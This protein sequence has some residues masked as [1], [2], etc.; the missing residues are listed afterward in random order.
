MSTNLIILI[1]CYIVMIGILIFIPQNTKKLLQNAGNLIFSYGRS[2]NIRFYTVCIVAFL[3]VFIV[4][5]Q[6]VSF[7]SIIIQLC[8][9]LGL[10]IV[11]KEANLKK[12]NGV[13]EKLLIVNSTFVEY[14][15]IVTF[16][17]LDLPKKEQEN[18]PK[19]VLV[20]ATES[21]GKVD[22]IFSSDEECSLVIEKLK[23]IKIITE[24]L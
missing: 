1:L 4:S 10:F 17:V 2:T 14:S 6:N 21:K 15:D 9:V 11:C 5:F 8:G 24:D 13:Y 12:H 22:L 19:N 18:Y 23:E 7:Y 3:L 16:P 20:V